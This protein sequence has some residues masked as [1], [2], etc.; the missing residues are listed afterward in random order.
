M[1]PGAAE[2]ENAKNVAVPAAARS[3]NAFLIEPFWELHRLAGG[4]TGTERRV[5]WKGPRR[6]MSEMGPRGL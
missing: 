6:A 1:A 2:A 3:G 4:G 5:R